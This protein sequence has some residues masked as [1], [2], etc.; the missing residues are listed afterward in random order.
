VIPVSLTNATRTLA[1]DQ[2]EYFPLDIVDSEMSGV[3]QMDSVWAP[4]NEELALLK[5]G[6]LVTLSILGTQHP[7]VFISVQPG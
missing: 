5:A 4:T 1:E 3:S 6:G 2:P 7:P